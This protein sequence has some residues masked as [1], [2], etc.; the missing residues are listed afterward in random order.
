MLSGPWS[1]REFRKAYVV[2]PS[3]A[4]CFHL[5][6][7]CSCDS[8]QDFTLCAVAREVAGIPGANRAALTECCSALG[9]A[10]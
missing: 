10:S 5:S 4:F 6:R 7:A 1:Q 8:S 2:W 3:P 9:Y